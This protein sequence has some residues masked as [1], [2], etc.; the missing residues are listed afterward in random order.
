MPRAKKAEPTKKTR[1]TTVPP[2]EKIKAL[3]QDLKRI[4]RELKAYK[5]AVAATH[6]AILALEASLT[7]GNR[8]PLPASR[9][10]PRT[11]KRRRKNAPAV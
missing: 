2:G 5:K 3:T 7:A 11:Q 9:T 10:A 6:T 1:A 8:K 4:E